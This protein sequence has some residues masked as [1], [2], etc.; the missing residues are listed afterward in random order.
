M[1][2]GYLCKKKQHIKMF[3]CTMRFCKCVFKLGVEYFCSSMWVSIAP[4]PVLLQ[5]SDQ[6]RGQQVGLIVN[7]RDRGLV[8]TCSSN[9]CPTIHRLAKEIPVYSS[10]I[11]IRQKSFHILLV[12]LLLL[13]S[14]VFVFNIQPKKILHELLKTPIAW[15]VGF[16]PTSGHL[17]LC[18]GWWPS[19]QTTPYHRT[20]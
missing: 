11:C 2:N 19:G 13:F 6:L 10:V 14:S 7:K 17:C 8:K 15:S 16:K 20:P 3:N 5:P 18:R 9:N 12:S 4:G 1:K